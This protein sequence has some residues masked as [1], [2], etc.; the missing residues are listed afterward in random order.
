[1]A[2]LPSPVPSLS[3]PLLPLDTATAVQHTQQTTA[4]ETEITEMSVDHIMLKYI[5]FTQTY[6]NKERALFVIKK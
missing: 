1:M 5:D 6:Y 4:A 2:E 3:D